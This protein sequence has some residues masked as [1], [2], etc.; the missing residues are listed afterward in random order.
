MA[1]RGTHAGL[2]ATPG[3]VYAALVARQAGAGGLGGEVDLAPHEIRERPGGEGGGGGEGD[4]AAAA[5]SL[6][7]EDGP[8][9]LEA[10]DGR[11]AGEGGLRPVSG[12]KL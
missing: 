4:G 11:A 12:E 3:S 7:P 9:S 2:L 10:A 5:S 1:E 8:D 6:P